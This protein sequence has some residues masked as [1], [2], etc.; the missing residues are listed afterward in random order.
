MTDFTAIGAM[1]KE[2]SL[3]VSWHA[4]AFKTIEDVQRSQ[5]AVA[6]TGAASTT[7]VYPVVLN[8][9]IGSNRLGM[10]GDI[11]KPG[12][13]RFYPSD[14]HSLDS[15]KRRVESHGDAEV[16]LPRQLA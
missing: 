12:L 10:A 9:I 5:M 16:A 3:C 7:D 4:S 15:S 11:E 8:A 1:A 2:V 14:R 13:Q 6:G